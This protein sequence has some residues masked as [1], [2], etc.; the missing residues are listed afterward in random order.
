M[1]ENDYLENYSPFTNDENGEM[2]ASTFDAESP[3]RKS[4]ETITDE[5]LAEYEARIRNLEKQSQNLESEL[6]HTRIYGGSDPPPNWPK[7]YPIIHYDIEEVPENSRGFVHDAFFSMIIM[8]VSFLMNW[9][10]TLCLLS[11]DKTVESPGSKIALSSL[12]F[13]ILIPLALDLDT[14]SV[15]RAMTTAVATFT[16]V[17]IFLA[18]GFTLILEFF[19]I[20]GM[21][22]SGS[23]GLITTIDLFVY[24]HIGVGIWGVL[25]IAALA[26]S[27]A[28]HAK[29][30]IKLWKYYR[31]TEV[32]GHMETDI[33]RTMTEYL[34]NRLK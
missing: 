33:Q 7:F 18:L 22:T 4:G 28:F 24:G 1:T 2:Q 13:F 3:P 11:T 9:I 14:L 8:A 25:V 23:V 17:K 21:D 15:Y 30:L 31:G 27:F 16:F 10:G 26:T 12:Y 29:L 5:Q 19:L 32:G 20:L 6:M 34:M